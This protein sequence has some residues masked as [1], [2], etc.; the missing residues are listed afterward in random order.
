[1]NKLISKITSFF[2]TSE[3][4]EPKA[5]KENKTDFNSLRKQLSELAVK[6]GK[7]YDFEL[8][9]SDESIKDVEKILGIF[10]NDYVK[11]KNEDGLVGISIEFGVYIVDT[12]EK[13]HGIG[14]LKQKNTDFGENSFPFH[15]KEGLLFPVAWCYKRI[16]DGESDNVWHKY[17]LLVIKD[18]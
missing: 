6:I 16:Y 13:N 7:S 1:M 14:E 9:Y 18:D 2:S 5:Q 3:K 11:T 8:D 15:W 4:N 12:I 10:H 17:R